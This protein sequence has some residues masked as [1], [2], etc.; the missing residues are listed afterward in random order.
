MQLLGVACRIIRGRGASMPSA[1]SSR[2]RQLLQVVV[3]LP[4]AVATQRNESWRA[5]VGAL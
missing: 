5:A 3:L 4:A 2:V 1:L